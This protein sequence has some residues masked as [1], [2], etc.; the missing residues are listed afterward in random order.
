[1]NAHHQKLDLT[2]IRL[3]HDRYIA[4]QRIEA[5]SDLFWVAC[6]AIA[7]Q[8]IDQTVEELLPLA[9][10]IA[11]LDISQTAMT[12]AAFRLLSQ[13]CKRRLEIAGGGAVEHRDT[14]AFI[15]PTRYGMSIQLVSR[16]FS[17]WFSPSFDFFKTITLAI[18][19]QD[20]NTVCQA[21]QQGSCQPFVTHMR[22]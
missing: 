13:M 2:L 12:P 8:V 11:W 22:A 10:H 9:A 6:S 16:P 14:G 20:M 4:F 21:V 5:S 17:R 18:G 15:Y 7:S 1:M 19:F 3:L